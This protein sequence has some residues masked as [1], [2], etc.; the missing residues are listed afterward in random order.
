[1]RFPWVIALAIAAGCTTEGAA[2]VP[3]NLP[4]TLVSEAWNLVVSD[5]HFA[6]EATGIGDENCVMWQGADREAVVERGHFELAWDP[7]S[8]TFAELY[9]RF[10]RPDGGETLRI[11]GPSPLAFEF[12]NLSLVP[13]GRAEV[14][15]GAPREG[16][17]ILKQPVVVTAEYLATEDFDRYTFACTVAG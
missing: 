8:P 2:T 1:M 13:D 7:I 4:A 6:G 15:V 16:S 11:Q 10:G 12:T 17:A 9:V 5:V 3:S 14:F